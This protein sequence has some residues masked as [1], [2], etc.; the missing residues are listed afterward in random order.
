ME[1]RTA[2]NIHLPSQIVNFLA[3]QV[4]G[5]AKDGWA[6]GNWIAD[7]M[8]GESIND[9]PREVQE[10]ILIHRH[11]DAFTDAHPEVK[12]AIAILRDQHHKYAPVVLDI[13]FDHILAKDF[14]QLTGFEISRF[15][16]GAYERLLGFYPFLLQKHQDRL[17]S[18]ISYR[19]LE[20]YHQLEALEDV[21][22]RL[23]RRARFRGNFEHA[24]QSYQTHQAALNAHF[25]SFWPELVAE[26]ECFSR[27]FLSEDS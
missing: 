19:W 8:K 27:Q 15:A 9:Y 13:L 21:F 20:K 2:P 23:K 26:T 1:L 7:L 14:E 11:I 5:A 16:A 24:I 17:D 12:A 10:G 4:L 22:L 25:D 18:M 3:H 6:L